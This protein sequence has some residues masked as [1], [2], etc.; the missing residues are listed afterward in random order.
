MLSSGTIRSTIP[1]GIM[2]NMFYGSMAACKSDEE[3]SFIWTS[4]L[5]V[6]FCR[7]CCCHE[8]ACHGFQCWR[9]RLRHRFVCNVHVKLWPLNA[10]NIQLLNQALVPGR[11][12][13]T[14]SVSEIPQALT[15]SKLTE[16][17]AR[18]GVK[19]I[20]EVENITCC[21]EWYS[22]VKH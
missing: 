22:L 10:C 17:N 9:L 7:I 21:R 18:L 3:I 12:G 11:P 6:L 15:A 16:F 5:Y 2:C 8:F 14:V 13:K 1:G 19:G 20:Q 4:N